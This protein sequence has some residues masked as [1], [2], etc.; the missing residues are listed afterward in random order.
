MTTTQELEAKIKAARDAYYNLDPIMTDHEYDALVDSLKSL[1]PT[2]EQVVSVGAPLPSSGDWGKV[3][4]EDPMGSLNK[5]N[6]REEFMEWAEWNCDYLI[7]HKLDGLSLELQY[8]DG[9]LLR[10]VTRGDGYVGEN[11]TINAKHLIGAIPVCKMGGDTIR[12]RGEVILPIDTFKTKYSDIYANPRNAAAGM[13]RDRKNGQELCKDLKFVA[14]WHS[15]RK[16]NHFKMFLDLQNGGFNIPSYI[17]PGNKNQI[18]LAFEESTSKREFLEYEIDGMVI[19][20]DDYQRFDGLGAKDR[21]PNGAIAWK[22]A[23]QT[24]VSKLVDVKW[25]VGP[26]GRINPIAV[27]EPVNI[28]GVT[29]TNIS[30][31][32]YANFKSMNLYKGA[33][34]MI[35]RKND[36]IPYVEGVVD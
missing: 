22:Y 13:L 19:Y 12:V 34:L 10:A 24:K 1:S 18:S 33:L 7:T 14:F 6:S 15:D 32:N 28:G 17:Y 3:T 35:S 4:H 8:E 29:I 26:T 5:V 27:V 16:M 31:Q 36:V 11:V 2:S 9:N 23:A 25:S 20:V 21:R 30:L